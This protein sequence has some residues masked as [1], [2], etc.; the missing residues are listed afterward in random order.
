MAIIPKIQW[1]TP[2]LDCWLMNSQLLWFSETVEWPDLVPW[3]PIIY[4][5]Y[6]VPKGTPNCVKDSRIESLPSTTTCNYS[7]NFSLV[8]SMYSEYSLR[9]I[10]KIKTIIYIPIYVAVYSMLTTRSMLGQILIKF[11]PWNKVPQKITFVII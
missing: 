6:I 5:L 9:D 4:L 11:I 3:F 7:S 10:S 2:T 8:W 1:K